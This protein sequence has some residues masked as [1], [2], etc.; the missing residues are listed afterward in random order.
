MGYR[1]LWIT[2]VEDTNYRTLLGVLLKD[3]TGQADGNTVVHHQRILTLGP[4]PQILVDHGMP[5]LPIVITGKVVDKVFFDHGITKGMLERLY[6]LIDTPKAIYKAHQG[7]PGSVVVTFENKGGAPIVVAVHPNKRM[8]GRSD[9]PN[10]FNNI[11]SIY[12]KQ[13]NTPGET[14]EVRWKREGLLLW[15]AAPVIPLP[16]AQPAAD[17]QQPA[18]DNAKKA[19]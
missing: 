4:T 5:Q 18:A 19:A 12:D 9:N 7:Q 17:A 15:E 13:S 3:M 8:G 2:Y 10:F 16:V 14:I 11:A 6:T 1:N